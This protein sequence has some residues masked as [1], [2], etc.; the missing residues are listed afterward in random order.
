MPQHTR[1]QIA[2]AAIG[3]DDLARGALGHRVDRKIAAL[4]IL[5][6]RDIGRELRREASVAGS[7]LALEAR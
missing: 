3:I 2:A 6:Q 5:V 7:Y 4:E 1:I